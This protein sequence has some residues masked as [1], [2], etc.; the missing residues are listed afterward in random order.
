MKILDLLVRTFCVPG[1]NIVTCA[2]AFIAYRLSAMIHGVDYRDHEPREDLVADLDAMAAACD[3]RTKIIFL[4]NPNNPTG[5]YVTETQLDP[6]LE[7]MTKKGIVV[8][9][10]SAYVEYVT[11]ADYV[12][13]MEMYRKYPNIVVTRTFSKAY[14]LAGIRVG[15]GIA[16]PTIISLLMRVK[17]PFNV[18]SLGLVAA[19]TALED[20][21][22]LKHCVSLNTEG[23]GFLEKE[24]DRLGV[25][26]WPSQ[27]NFILVDLAQ[28]VA[29]I[30][31]SLLEKGV[32]V[33]PVAG[34]GLK[35]HLRITIGSTEENQ[36]MVE[37]LEF[38]LKG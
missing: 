10:D 27:G 4:P 12:N 15:Y 38:V 25:R 31:Q 18:N 13:P 1:D 24:F 36:R 30:N 22:H 37:S 8:V 6:F 23:M 20:E 2:A 29:G 3:E 16:H 17:M 7:K 5:T 26:Y 14:G 11:A 33:R 32:I 9:L 35:T 19:R 34:F 21:A 28:D